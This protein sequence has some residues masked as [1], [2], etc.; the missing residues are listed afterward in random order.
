MFGVGFGL[1]EIQKEP[2]LMINKQQTLGFKVPQIQ[3][4]EVQLNLEE[5]K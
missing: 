4:S 1:A 5:P 3:L 2:S